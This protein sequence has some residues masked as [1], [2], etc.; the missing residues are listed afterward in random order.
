VQKGMSALPPIATSIASFG[1]SALGLADVTLF[2]HLVGGQKQARQYRYADRRRFRT[3]RLY[4]KIGRL[5]AAQDTVDAGRQ[6][7]CMGTGFGVT[8]LDANMRSTT[9]SRRRRDGA[10]STRKR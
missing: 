7:L 2:D 4:R 10:E 3:W 1:M 8:I 9:A 5:V 6:R